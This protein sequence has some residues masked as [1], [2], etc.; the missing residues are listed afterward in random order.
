MQNCDQRPLQ[1]AFLIPPV[2]P[3]VLISS[4]LHG[5]YSR[6]RDAGLR[7]WYAPEDM[8]RGRKILDQLEVAIHLQD[9][10]LLVLSEASMQSGWVETELRTALGREQTE[11]RQI[12]FPI[13]I[14][15]DH[16]II[17]QA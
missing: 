4:E 15:I 12:V 1:A 7:V 10:L 2:L 17:N 3:V 16:R 13:R 8:K 5:L 11:K 6:A 9:K 14:T